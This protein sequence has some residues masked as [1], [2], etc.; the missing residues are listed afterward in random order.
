MPQPVASAG[1]AQFFFMEIAIQPGGM[2]MSKM[3]DGSIRSGSTRYLVGY[4]V[5]ELRL[6]NRKTQESLASWRTDT[7][8]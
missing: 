2:L 5:R 6:K 8:F 1:G 7:R 4:F 3:D